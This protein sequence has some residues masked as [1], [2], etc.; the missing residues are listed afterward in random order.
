MPD[1]HVVLN[2]DSFTNKGVAGNL[3]ALAYNS[4]LLNLNEGA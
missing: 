4:I 1:K 2:N 3:A